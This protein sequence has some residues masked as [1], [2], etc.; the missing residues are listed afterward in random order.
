MVPEGYVRFLNENEERQ[1]L[2]QSPPSNT[3]FPRDQDPS[4]LSS[5]GDET[6][7]QPTQTLKGEWINPELALNE[8]EWIDEQAPQSQPQA[9]KQNREDWNDTDSQNRRNESVQK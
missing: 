4:F 6:P 7:R 9:Q 2:S 1:Y 3:L 8:G 5:S